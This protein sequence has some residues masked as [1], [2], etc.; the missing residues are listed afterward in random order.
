MAPGRP[1]R[2]STTPREPLEAAADLPSDPAGSD[3]AGGPAEGSRGLRLGR[4]PAPT[5]AA[6]RL[7]TADAA[8]ATRGPVACPHFG[9]C[10]GCSRLG[11]SYDDELG[12]KEEAL[13]EAVAAVPSLESARLEPILGADTPLHYRASLKVPFAQ[14]PAGPIAGF[15]ERGSHRIVDLQTCLIQHPVLTELL[16]VVR[17]LVTVC[18]VPLYHEHLHRGVLR[19]LVA[20]VAPGT[21]EVLAGLVVRRA[22]APQ[23][24]R[25]AWTLH[26]RL[27][28]RG[29]VGVVENVNPERTNAVLGPRSNRLVGRAVMFEEIDGLR[30]RTSIESFSQVNPAQASRLFA[31]VA[32]ALDPLADRL[33]VDL[34][35]GYGPIAL[36]LAKGGARVIAIERNKVAV[37]DGAAIARANGLDERVEFVAADAGAGLGEQLARARPDALVVDPPRRGLSDEVKALLRELRVARLVYVSC[38]PVTLLRDLEELAPAY[39]TRAIRPVDLFPRTDHVEAIATLDARD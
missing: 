15:F 7:P 30:L 18:A 21:E 22:G 24:K 31:E 1:S 10:G 35:S 25:L 27:K 13:R 14:S 16:H 17:E 39:V 8:P 4:G 20:R 36:R 23:I 32:R 38:N 29:L 3:E 11:I 33:V 12:L 26:E 6:E 28:D 19:H 9:P 2:G 37:R 5:P 34:Y